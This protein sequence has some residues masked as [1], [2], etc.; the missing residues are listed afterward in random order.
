M[1]LVSYERD[2]PINPVFSQWQEEEVE[3]EEEVWDEE[4]TKEMARAIT[5][6][7]KA[8]AGLPPISRACMIVSQLCLH[9]ILAL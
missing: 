5:E 6:A 7:K 1:G 9:T 4:W 2:T 3:E 8:S